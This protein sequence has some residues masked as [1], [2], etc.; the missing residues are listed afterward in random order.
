MGGSIENCE[1]SSSARDA[2]RSA[3]LTLRVPGEKLDELI[4]GM[5][6]LG[7]IDPRTDDRGGHDRYLHGQRIPTGE[8]TR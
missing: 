2:S 1:I 8:R 5:G 4:E 7:G 3:S 6:E